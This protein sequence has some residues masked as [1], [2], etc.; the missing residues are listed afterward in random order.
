VLELPRF[1]PIDPKE[2]A[3]FLVFCDI[4]KGKLDPFRGIPIK[5]AAFLRYVES[6]TANPSKCDYRYFFD[7]LEDADP[8]VAFDALREFVQAD[9]RNVVPLAKDLPADKLA[10]W[11]KGQPKPAVPSELHRA[12]VRL[13]AILLGDCG[14]DAHARLLRDLLDA[15]ETENARDGLLV[16]YALLK[17]REGLTL[18]REQFQA[19]NK[20]LSTR[21]SA[22]QAA[23]FLLDFPT[24][25]VERR[26]ILE[27]LA[28][29][30][31]HKD[32]SDLAV[33]ELRRRGY[34][35]K[36]ERILRLYGDNDLAP[37]QRRAVVRYALSRPKDPRAV[38]FL[39]RLRCIEGGAQLV[40]DVAETLELE[41]NPKPR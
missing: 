25:R 36:T 23:R 2:P 8:D 5:S 15:P 9:Y 10:G 26:Q 29:M 20:E 24:D 27:A 13:Y 33:E 14:S 31:E 41:Q 30:L 28:C 32:V 16:G 22:L 3:T 40:D 11:L 12:R 6:V 35:E 17:P 34:C 39:L 19:P 18:L 7:H 37:V 21:L 38:K 4:H 1:V